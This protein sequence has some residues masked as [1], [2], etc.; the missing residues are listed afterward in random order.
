MRK[1]ALI[2]LAIAMISIFIYI[3]FRFEFKFAMSA[4]LGLA[5]DV[6]ISLGLLAIFHKLGVQVQINMETIAA[7]MTIIGYSLNDTIIIFDRIREDSHIMRKH[8]F[9]DIVNHALNTTLSRTL[10]TSG[11]TLIVLLSLVIFGGNLIF[12]FVLLMTIGVIIGTL[13]SLFIVSPILLYFHK[14]EPDLKAV[15]HA[16]SHT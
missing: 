10:I 14:K 7:M 3:T 8:S 15:K 6:L 1:N 2:G 9:I 11:T 16:K 4:I 12:D 13:S 5:H